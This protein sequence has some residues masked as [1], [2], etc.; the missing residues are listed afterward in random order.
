MAEQIFSVTTDYRREM[1]CKITSGAVSALPPVAWV[2]FGDGGTDEQGNVLTP[3]GSQTALRHE[4]AR[5]PVDR[6]DYPAPATARYTVNIPRRDLPGINIS[7]AAL[8]D[9]G[10]ALCAI[11]NMRPKGKDEDVK[12]VFE[13]D[14]E[15]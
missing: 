2:A 12:F 11:R 9:A 3:S 4:V 14:D 6:V 13:F 7:E 15:F 10:G 1:L 5:Y 8:V